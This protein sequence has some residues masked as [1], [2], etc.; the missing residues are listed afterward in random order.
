[1][2]DLIYNVKFQID[3]SQF[4][5]ESAGVEKYK[6]E[7][8]EANAEIAELKAQLGGATAKSKQFVNSNKN[9]QGSTKRM[10]ASFSSANQTLFSFS[11]GL[12]DSAQFQQ[13]FGTGM[14]AIGNNV[15]FT[16]ELFGNLNARVKEHNTGLQAQVKAGNMST[17]AM[18]EQSRTLKGELV[19]ALKGPGGALIAINLVVTGI[20]ILT[21]H[22][23]SNNK[24][25]EEAAEGI[26]E[27][28][29]A[30]KTLRGLVTPDV[31]QLEGL[32]EEEAQLEQL[33]RLLERRDVLE[34]QIG[35]REAPSGPQPRT[36]TPTREL[37]AELEA[38]EQQLQLFPIDVGDRGLKEL[39]EALEGIKTTIKNVKS[40][41]GG[42]KAG[43]GLLSDETAVNTSIAITKFELGLEGSEQALKN[44]IASTQ[45]QIDAFKSIANSY[46]ITSEQQDIYATLL[47]ALVKENEAAKKALEGTND[48]LD[49]QGDEYAE[50]KTLL[51]ALQIEEQSTLEVT[52]VAREEFISQ[53]KEEIEQ[54]Q[55]SNLALDERVKK[56]QEL[57]GILEQ[58]E[59]Q[60]EGGDDG[61]RAE[62]DAE[63]ARELEV[64]RAQQIDGEFARALRVREI[65]LEN[66]QEMDLTEN[67]FALKRFEINLEYEK[68]IQAIREESAEK[69]RRIN[70]QVTNS[71]KAVN[72]QLVSG[73]QSAMSGLLG[74][75]K[76]TALL[77]LAVEKSLAIGKVISDARAKANELDEEAISMSAKSAIALVTGNPVEAGQFASAAAIAKGASATALAT[78]RKNA[79]KIAAIGLLQGAG[80]AASG[81][82]GGSSV[83]GGGASA[84]GGGTSPRGGEEA[85]FS[86]PDEPLAY[87]PRAN[88]MNEGG[89]KTIVNFNVDETGFAFNV[90]GADGVA[91]ANT[92]NMTSSDA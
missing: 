54:V 76:T 7:V 1:M 53:V 29:D 45:D 87:N 86:T 33:I 91:G 84:G 25:A 85:G 37:K 67:E 23:D 56:L 49:E 10:N 27:Y 59:A 16:A 70:E 80:I 22:F 19:G 61:G 31:T 83:G 51:G 77:T 48:A 30:I 71:S 8:E 88:R 58:L 35:M 89:R 68:K 39:R 18:K 43:L 81:G 41:A 34:R 9:V 28:A 3:D 12:Q 62:R 47:Q 52:S 66:L 74:K 11:D 69:V 32:V 2:P 72:D 6:Q 14:R 17:Q 36:T 13:G 92:L 65:Q 46:D 5:R 63:A 60:G 75:N 50:L 44:Q 20:T 64:L 78:G 21:N 38:L 55:Q 57:L 82:G 26:S 73:L 90:Q 4:Q 42:L 24:K 40:S 15:G 79:A